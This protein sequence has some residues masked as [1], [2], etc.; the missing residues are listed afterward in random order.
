MRMMPSSSDSLVYEECTIYDGS[1]LFAAYHYAVPSHSG[2]SV[3]SDISVR[4][5]SSRQVGLR[6]RYLLSTNWVTTSRRLTA[7]G[8]IPCRLIR[9][10]TKDAL[11][12][13]AVACSLLITTLYPATLGTPYFQTYL[14]VWCPA[15]KSV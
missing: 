4:I 3:P 2:C 14:S 9:C 8:W 10:P 7:W 11:S 5:A 13:T 15:G 6:G 1:G 12:M